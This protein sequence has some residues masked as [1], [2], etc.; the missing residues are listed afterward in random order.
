MHSW[1]NQ[2]LN[3]HHAWAH[4]ASWY[5]CCNEQLDMTHADSGGLIKRHGTFVVT[6]NSICIVALQWWVF[7]A[8]WHSCCDQQLTHASCNVTSTAG[9]LSVMAL[10]L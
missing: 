4:Q 2:Q 9:S 3:M 1:C 6:S 7:Q 10:L 8:Y 5:S